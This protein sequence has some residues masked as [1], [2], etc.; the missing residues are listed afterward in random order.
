MTPWQPWLFGRKG[1]P[2]K[3]FNWI[4]HIFWGPEDVIV[5]HIAYD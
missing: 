3:G 4:N 2:A 1:D 5:V